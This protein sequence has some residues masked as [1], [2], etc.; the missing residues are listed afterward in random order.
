[1]KPL[2]REKKV[3]CF[4]ELRI[5]RCNWTRASFCPTNGQMNSGLYGTKKR[6]SKTCWVPRVPLEPPDQALPDIKS[7]SQYLSSVNWRG[8]NWAPLNMKLSSFQMWAHQ[9]HSCLLW[10]FSKFRF[11]YSSYQTIVRRKQYPP[12]QWSQT[13]FF[14]TTPHSR[15]FPHMVQVHQILKVCTA[16]DL[17]PSLWGAIP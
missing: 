10:P 3:F 8:S 6:R 13:E 12:N 17:Q 7:C 15:G 16:E 1:M 14:H 11:F 2:R 5:R 9:I 4:S